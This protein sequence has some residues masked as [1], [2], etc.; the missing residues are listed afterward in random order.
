MLSLR[1][2][3]LLHIFMYLLL[4]FNKAYCILFACLS[5]FVR[6]FLIGARIGACR[7]ITPRFLLEVILIASGEQEAVQRHGD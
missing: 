6:F 7:M 4:L 2:V 5:S 1:Y 3:T